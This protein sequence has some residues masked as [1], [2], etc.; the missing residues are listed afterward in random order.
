MYEAINKLDDFDSYFYLRE[1]LPWKND[2]ADALKQNE[3]KKAEHLLLDEAGKSSTLEQVFTKALRHQ[4]Y[5][6]GSVDDSSVL[7][8]QN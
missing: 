6:S 7:Y 1:K 3:G 2:K 4:G 5:F 8:D